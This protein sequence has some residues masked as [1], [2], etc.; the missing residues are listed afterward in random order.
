MDE[1]PAV[2]P[3][4]D[5]NISDKELDCDI[6]KLHLHEPGSYIATDEELRALYLPGQYDRMME[7]FKNLY[8]YL[9]GFALPALVYGLNRI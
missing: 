4:L 9:A 1:R 2:P 3:G 8:N 5:Y 7:K 6:I